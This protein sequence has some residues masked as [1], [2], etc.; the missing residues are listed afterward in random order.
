LACLSKLKSY[1]LALDGVFLTGFGLA[2]LLAVGFTSLES[3]DL[4]LAALFL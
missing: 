2:A 1:F 4:I 3:L